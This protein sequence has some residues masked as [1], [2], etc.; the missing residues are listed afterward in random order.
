MIFSL[1]SPDVAAAELFCR[2]RGNL[3]PCF[4]SLIHKQMEAFG[5]DLPKL[6]QPQTERACSSRFTSSFRPFGAVFQLTQDLLNGVAAA[7]RAPPCT[8]TIPHQPCGAAQHVEYD[9]S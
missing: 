2:R 8:C 6:I 3:W 4:P 9:K 5:S 1:F 7:V